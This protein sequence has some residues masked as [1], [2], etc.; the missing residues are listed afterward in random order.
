MMNDLQQLL[1][2]SRW[3]K[4]IPVCYFYLYKRTE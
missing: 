4:Q 3:N 2:T 1:R